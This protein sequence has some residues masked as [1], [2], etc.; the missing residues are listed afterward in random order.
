MSRTDGVPLFVE[1]L[2]KAVLKF[3]LLRSVGDHFEL[4]GPLPRLRAIPATLMIRYGQA[5]SYW[6]SKGNRTD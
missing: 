1:Q 3:D 6:S 4:A 2:T 5:R